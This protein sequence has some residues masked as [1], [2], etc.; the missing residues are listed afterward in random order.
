MD[1]MES[2]GGAI[3]PVE[4]PPR[5]EHCGTMKLD[6][7]QYGRCFLEDKKPAC[8]KCFSRYLRGEP[9]WVMEKH[10]CGT[11]ANRYSN[12]KPARWDC[13]IRGAN[14]ELRRYLVARDDGHSPGWLVWWS[15]TGGVGGASL[16]APEDDAKY[17]CGT[18]HRG[19]WKS[20]EKAMG[21]CEFHLQQLMP[22]VAPLTFLEVNGDARPRHDAAAAAIFDEEK[23]RR[24]E[25]HAAS[26]ASPAASEEA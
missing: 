22:M 15:E 3:A 19:A 18:D 23:R 5:C 14:G 12:W 25:E 26:Y 8:A 20:K 4:M 24:E 13:L 6:S 2:V 11:H 21:K 17:I 16:Y 10:W 1:R 9:V 7:R